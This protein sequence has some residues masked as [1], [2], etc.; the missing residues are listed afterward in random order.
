MEKRNNYFTDKILTNF[1]LNRKSI[2]NYDFFE[3][4][5]LVLYNNNSFRNN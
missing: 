2:P 1:N 4:F 3:E 5:K